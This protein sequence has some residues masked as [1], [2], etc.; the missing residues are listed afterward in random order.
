MGTVV[1]SGEAAPVRLEA[2]GRLPHINIDGFLRLVPTIEPVEVNEAV[3]GVDTRDLNGTTGTRVSIVDDDTE[4]LDG[5]ETRRDS[6]G[7]VIS[8]TAVDT[9][10]NFRLLA[11][12]P[13]LPTTR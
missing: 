12:D 1:A 13:V 5:I 7:Q 3:A 8:S 4:L 11:D 9:E 10:P 6:Y 2:F